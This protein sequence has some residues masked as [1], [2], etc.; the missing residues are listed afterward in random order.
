MKTR[1]TKKRNIIRRTVAFLL[2]MTM[3]LGLGMQDVI[4]QVYA[5]EASAVSREQ[6]ADV[7]AT[8][9]VESTETTTPEGE[10]DPTASEETGPATPEEEPTA[11]EEDKKPVEPTNPTNPEENTEVT[12]PPT[13]TTK[14]STPE[15]PTTPADGTENTETDESTD[16]TAPVN[17]DGSNGSESSGETTTTPEE[18]TGTDEQK[19]PVEEETKEES[20]SEL[21]Y[22]A[23]DG[24][25]SVKAAAVSEDVDLSGIEI[26]ASQ[27]QKDGEEADRYAAAEELV[28]GAL[29]AESR[30]IEELQAYD[31]WFTYTESGETADLSG[32]VQISLEYTE[33]EFP[34][35]TDAQLEVFCLNDGAAEAVDGTDA[36]AAGCELY[37]LAWTVPSESTDTWEWADGQVII[38]ASAD[39]GV[40]PEGAEISVTPIVKTE[41]EELANLSEEERAEAEAINE[42]YA[43][44]EEK[45]TEDLEVQ[46]AEEAAALPAAEEV[47]ADAEAADA[48]SDSEETADAATAKTL[49]GFLAYDICFLANGEEVEPADGEVNVSIEFN[50]AVIPEGVSEDAEVSVAHLKEEKNENGEDEIVVEDLTSAETT[51]VETTDKAEVKKVELVTESFSTFTIYWGNGGSNNKITVHYVE[52]V[53]GEVKEIRGKLNNDVLERGESAV[54]SQANYGDA[55][56]GYSFEEARINNAVDGTEVYSVK[57]S[58]RGGWTY[59]TQPNGHDKEW[60]NSGSSGRHVYLVYEKLA[61]LTEVETIENA[62]GGITMRMTNYSSAA[63]GLDQAIGGGYGDGNV[64]QG[65]LNPVLQENGY[66][67]TDS[68]DD[69]SRLFQ[70]G[71]EVDNLFIKS[72]YDETGYYEYSSF[73]NYA[74]LN[75]NG[76]FTV[77]EQLGTP[78]DHKND[79]NYYYNRGNFLPYN[80]LDVSVSSGNKN[81]YDEEGESL[82]GKDRYGETLYTSRDKTDYYFGMYMEANFSQ[83]KDGQVEYNGATNPMI[84]EF[85]GDDDLWIY[86]DDVLVLDIGG[87]HDAHSGYINFATG[88][89]HVE[90]INTSGNDQDITIKEMYRLA[91]V[92]PDGSKWNDELVDNY[93]TGDTFKN[94][95]THTMKMFYME[96]GAGASNLHMRFNLQTV[97]SG[98][99]EV[100][101]ELTNTDKDKYANVQFAFQMLAQ[102]VTGQDGQGNEIYSEKYVTL[103]EATYGDSGESIDFVNIKVDDTTYEN[104]FYLKPGETARF[105]DLQSDR[106]YY[107]REI[108]VKSEEYD[109][110]IINGTDIII[111]GDGGTSALDNIETDPIEVGSGGQVTFQNSCSVANRRELQITKKMAEGQTTN[112]TF[113]FQVLLEGTESEELIP[114]EGK[115]YLTKTE[116]GKKT[117]YHYENGELVA[118]PENEEGPCGTV[119]DGKIEQIP[120]GYTVAITQILSDTK[121]KV[122][123]ND[124]NEGLG[125]ECYKDPIYDVQ[126]GTADGISENGAAE[127]TIKLGTDAVVTITNTLLP[128]PDQEM[129]R[130]QK[131][132]KGLT[133]AQIDTLAGFLINVDDSILALVE[134]GNAFVPVSEP[135]MGSN[136]EIIYNWMIPAG[137]PRY[138]VSESGQV[139]TPYVVTTTVN[140]QTYTDGRV[141]VSGNTFSA[142]DIVLTQVENVNAPSDISLNSINLMVIKQTDGTYVVWSKEVLSVGERTALQTGLV[143]QGIISEGADVKYFSTESLLTEEFYYTGGKISVA[144]GKLSF[145]L[146]KDVKPEN[147]NIWTGTY[148]MTSHDAEIEVVN[149]YTLPEVQIDLKK[150]GTDYTEDNLRDGAVF[151]LYKG[152][153]TDNQGGVSIEW[154]EEAMENYESIHVSGTGAPELTI[155]EGYYKLVEDTAPSGYQK[156]EEPI[157]F[158]VTITVDGANI[159]WIDEAGN[160]LEEQTD[161][162]QLDESGDVLTIQ[163]KND[164]LYDLPEAGGPGIHLYMLGGVALMMAGTLL[165]YKKR[166]EEV[167]RS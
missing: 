2:C 31:I 84:Y 59:K 142:N 43:Q 116:N 24:S 137:G 157:C 51:I 79:T 154:P 158:K 8:Q 93:F 153:A 113:S 103:S 95:T 45:L 104:V 67:K 148:E 32:Q 86:I 57:Y 160:E 3:V 111:V 91:G 80:Q 102:E 33:P 41:E 77:Y 119:D 88:A 7:P 159:V 53:D 52:I 123:E 82:Y 19:P 46:A 76:D 163:I 63:A 49:E 25:F 166:K 61:E 107:V 145:E 139:L 134:S 114:Y 10:T 22:A 66:P 128:T 34:E 35:G 127:G 135:V 151:S 83:P 11:S 40:L 126:D 47:T 38:K 70:N 9:E 100:R 136:G 5:E 105:S 18:G 122:V 130:V 147:V 141:E 60:E 143:G 97:P 120:V 133:Q 78:S 21:T 101:K 85:N 81:L 6:S 146:E 50:E 156:L 94:Y 72:T 138:S 15:E 109:K 37:A 16:L 144:D 106:K 98:T 165:V 36:L 30:Q 26:H 89:V 152:V 68:G 71:Q 64:K 155:G 20:V 1:K 48:A 129:I 54:F 161:M 167:L 115:Y 118:F 121:F 65:L 96:R 13:E 87:V 73:Q 56:Q 44:T 74:Y 55:V 12:T 90:C 69:L 92:F 117:Y 112:D 4:E 124:P 75:S 99:V 108:G 140:E 149:T 17:P 164:T 28:V 125:T 23:E 150:Y 14:P 132:F 162:W 39:K 42:Q 27:I 29:D 62:V 131:T 110:V 58:Q